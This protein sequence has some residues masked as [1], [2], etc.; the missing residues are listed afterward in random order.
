MEFSFGLRGD[1]N[2]ARLIHLPEITVSKE[3]LLPTA[4]C[5]AQNDMQGSP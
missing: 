5:L 2:P 1:G 4:I 3:E